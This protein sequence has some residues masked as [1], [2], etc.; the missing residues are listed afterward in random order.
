MGQLVVSPGSALQG[1]ARTGWI[2]WDDIAHLHETQF[3]EASAGIN[4][5]ENSFR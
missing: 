1:L 4:R 3:H 2:G 5:S